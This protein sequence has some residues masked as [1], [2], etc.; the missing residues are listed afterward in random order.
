MVEWDG[1]YTAASRLDP[2]VTNNSMAR[3]VNNL[4]AMG[5]DQFAIQLVDD[6]AENEAT[7]ALIDQFKLEPIIKQD[8]IL[9]YVNVMVAL[10]KDVII[11]QIADRGDVVS[12]Q[13]WIRL[14]SIVS[15]RTSS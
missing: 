15:G 12:I 10:P 2:T 6:P 3:I 13:P 8:R 7:L 5:N 4:S 14:R 1:E 11:N 9:G